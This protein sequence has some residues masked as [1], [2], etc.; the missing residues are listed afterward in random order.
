MKRVFLNRKAQGGK[1]EV[2]TNRGLRKTNSVPREKVWTAKKRRRSLGPFQVSLKNIGVKGSATR[3][4]T[5]KR[6]SPRGCSRVASSD[7]F[8]DRAGFIPVGESEG[9]DPS[10]SQ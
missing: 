8:P 1:Q 4:V 10:P 3:A 7:P 5:E 9:R 2:L 6:R